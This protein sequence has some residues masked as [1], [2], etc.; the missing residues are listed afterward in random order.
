VGQ[1]GDG[2]R[3]PAGPGVHGRPRTPMLTVNRRH[4]PR[5]RDDRLA[6]PVPTGAPPS[7]TTTITLE[8]QEQHR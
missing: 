5:R 4:R 6:R 1:V 2:A 3:A 8:S 7:I